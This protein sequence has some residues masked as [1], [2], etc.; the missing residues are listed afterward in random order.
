MKHAMRMILMG[1]V[2]ALG[3]AV[4]P[5][6]SVPYNVNLLANPG[7]ESSS[8]PWVGWTQIANG[9]DGLVAAAWGN[10]HSGSNLF[11]TSSGWMQRCQTNN[12]LSLGFTAA[13]LDSAPAI[14]VGEWFQTSP[15]YGGQFYLKVELRDASLNV[16]AGWTNGTVASPVVWGVNSNWTL[17]AHTFTNYGAGVR[18]VRFEDGGKD[19]LNWAGNYGIMLDDAYV[20]VGATCALMPSSN[21]PAAGGNTLI[22]TN[23]YPGSFGSGSDITNVVFSN[24]NQTVSATGANIL[25]QGS[26]WV[27]VVVPAHS[28]GSVSLVIQ[29]SGA[30]GNTTLSS[31]Q[32]TF[33][34][35]GSIGGMQWMDYRITF[36]DTGPLYPTNTAQDGA[37][38]WTQ[39][40]RTNTSSVELIS[41]GAV[42]NAVYLKG[43][44]DFG[45]LYTGAWQSNYTWIAIEAANTFMYQPGPYTNC[46]VITNLQGSSYQVD[47]VDAYPGSVY[48]CYIKVFPG[49]FTNGASTAGGSY[50][51]NASVWQNPGGGGNNVDC[52]QAQNNHDRYITWTNVVP[53]NGVISLVQ[54]CISGQYN[55]LNCMRIRGLEPVTGGAGAG[56]TPS[57]GSYT[58]G[59]PVTISGSNLCNGILGDVTNVTLCGITGVVASVAGSTQIVVTA[60]AAPN[61]SVLGD[62]RVYSISYGLSVKTNGFTYTGAG[63]MAVRGTNGAVIASGEAASTT[64]GT[65]FGFLT[66]GLVR[67]NTFSITNSGS[68]ALNISGVT[69]NGAGAS[70]FSVSNMPSSVAAGSA[71]N[72]TVRFALTNATT[73]AAAVYIVN[74]STTTPYIINLAGTGGKLSQT[75]SGFAPQN[76]TVF[77]NVSMIARLS[78]TASSGLAVTFATNGGPG[79]IAGGTNLSFSSTGVVYVVASQTGNV[80]YAAAP[81]VTNTYYCLGAPYWTSTPVTNA[82]DGELYTYT[83]TAAGPSGAPIS[84]SGASL[85]P[86]LTMTSAGFVSGDGIISTMAGNGSYGSTG[87]GGPATNAS[88][89]NIYRVG[90]DAAGNVY[91]PD[92]FNNRVRK[93]TAAGII[94]TIAGT[95]VAGWSGDGGAATNAKLNMPE[96]ACVDALGVVYIT[97]YNNNLIRRVGTNGIITTVAGTG[98]YGYSGDGGPATNAKLGCPCETAV[99]AAGNLFVVDYGNSR[100][101]RIGTNG[102]IQTIAGTGAASYNGDG[103]AATNAT[104]N[105]PQS[106]VVDTAGNVLVGDSGNNRIRRIGTNGIIRTIAGTGTSGY[107]GDEIAATNAQLNNPN[108]MTFDADGN[109]FMA[110]YGNNR[111]RRIGTNGIIS[112][113]AGSGIN[114]FSGDGGSATN[115]KMSA[116]GVAVDSA[117]RLLIADLYHNRIRRVALSVSAW[118]LS[119]TPGP[120]YVGATNVTLWATSSSGSTPQIFTLTIAGRARPL[121]LS[122]ALVVS[123]GVAASPVSGTDFGTVG[124]NT[125]ESLTLSITNSGTA[126]MTVSGISTSGANAAFFSIANL[127]ASLAVGAS[128]NFDISYRPMGEGPHAASF[129][130]NNNGTNTPYIINVAGSG[131]RSGQI[132]LNRGSMSYSATYRGINPPVQTFV[133]TNKGPGAFSYSNTDS[134]A[135]FT[136]APVTGYLA[137]G[138]AR[139]HTG[140]VSIA[141]SNAGTYSATN[142]ITSE[143]ATN[144]PVNMLIQLTIN[145]AT[146][147]I[148]FAAIADQKITNTVGLR[149]TASSSNAV[150]FY[151]MLGSPGVISGTNLT[152]TG[153]GT[154]WVVASQA[155]DVNYTAAPSVTNSINVTRVA[156]TVTLTNLNHTYDGNV[157]TASVTT[158]PT[159]LNVVVNYSSGSTAPSNAGSYAVTALINE[160]FYTGTATGTLVIARANQTINF[161]AIPNQSM[162]NAVGL[163]ATATSS[164]A[165]TFTV[166]SGMGIINGTNL[167]FAGAGQVKITAD[168]AGDNNWNAAPTVTN[169][170]SVSTI[171]VW[172]SANVTNATDGA[173]YTYTLTATD[174]GGMA[175]TFNASNL[176]PWLTLSQSGGSSIISTI[177]GKGTSAYSGDNGPA[178]NAGLAQVYDVAADAAGNIY[179]ADYN[180]CRIRKISTNGII[181]TVAGNGVAG[182]SGDGGQATNA[183]VYCPANVSVNTQGVIYITD[184]ASR[185]RRVGTNGIITLFAGT[186]ISSFSGDGGAATNARMNYPC[187]TAVDAVGKLYIAD[188]YNNRVR[189]VGTDGII[190]TIAG[191]GTSGF[192]GDGGPATS[193][194]FNAP[195]DVKVD[196]VGNV[197]VLDFGNNRVRKINTTSGVISTIAGTGTAGYNGDGISATNAKL[198]GARALALDTAGNVYVADYGNYR[199]RRIGTNGLISTIAGS[200]AN[201]FSGDGG[202]ATNASM[203]RP[204]GVVVDSSGNVVISD[205]SNYRIRRVSASGAMT[206]TLSGTPGPGDV[207]V[208]N[209]TLYANNGTLSTS[210]SF[211]ITV[212]GTARPLLLNR[213]SGATIANGAYSSPTLGTDFGTVGTN[214]VLLLSLSI[215]NFG[216]APLTISGVSTSGYNFSSFTFSNLP[217][218]V[219]AGTASN[220]ALVYAPGAIGTAWATL[221][222]TNNGTNSPYVIKVAGYATR[223]GA[224]G[225]SRASFNY[226]STYGG[227]NPVAQTYVITN[228]VVGGAGFSY[229]NASGAAWFSVNAVTGYLASA[230]L[231]PTFTGVGVLAADSASQ[232]HTGMVNCV[233][234]NAGSYTTTNTLSSPTASNS[235]VNMLVNLTIAQ[236]NQ[237]ITFPSVSD[238]WMTNTVGLNATAASGLPVSFNVAS[239]PGSISGTNLTFS[240]DGTVWVVA[241]QT[242]NLNY[243]AALAVTNPVNVSKSVATV[244]LSNL[245]Y[246]YDCNVHTATVATIPAALNVVVSYGGGTTPSNAGSYSVSAQVSATNYTGTATGTLVIARASQVITN[247]LPAS[248]SQDITNTFGLSA[249]ASSGLTVTNFVVVSGMATVTGGA[250][251]TF[252][253]AGS[254]LV[255]ATQAGDDNYNAA[256]NVTNTYTVASTPC[257]SSTPVTNATEGLIY[258]YTLTGID[259]GGL[260]VTFRT[261]SVPPWL[262]LTNTPVNSIISTFAGN[263]IYGTP[264]NGGQAT[265]SSIKFP[266][267][268]TYDRNGDV[269]MADL[270]N[271][272]IYK[273]T[274]SGVISKFAGTGVAGYSG[275]GGAATSAG[276]NGP[277]GVKA[278]AAGNIYISEYYGNRIRKVNTNGIISTIAGTGTSG[279]SGDGGAATSAKLNQPIAITVDVAGN[280]FVAEWPGYRI[281]MINPSGIISTFAG[282]G[283]QGFSGDGGAATNAKISNPGG[284]DTDSSGNLYLADT[285][286]NV[287]RRIG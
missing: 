187:G 139:I 60:G 20:N 145:Q 8:N 80:S 65:D 86:W 2:T 21:G 40:M 37:V 183:A 171:P 268:Q 180:A 91:V 123:N 188:Y 260:A 102:I 253:A 108:G 81:P 84:F 110:D 259:P 50:G 257:W 157:H 282:T 272:I 189:R 256:P 176:P 185:I 124:S 208:T 235:P 118:T 223:P 71:S 17:I 66:P 240:G 203:T 43:N 219:A 63:I 144:S 95:G 64:N 169:S 175:V 193:A 155:G 255:A 113:C 271:S 135:W 167:T 111:V 59:Y 99:D 39:N 23:F 242:G 138:T 36:K 126:A 174:P 24:T 34:P 41:T 286:N 281:R 51:L 233:G 156:A 199:I 88:F 85:P 258:T 97:D 182:N 172:T 206:W 42:L 241:S 10:Q 25:G 3:L 117:G 87:D 213:N 27:R 15:S 159:N 58:G 128:S 198:N 244:T 52:Q 210:N 46:T 218:V 22:I 194:T 232:T 130:I 142:T 164:N 190:Q 230:S 239:G 79:L 112:T 170:L 136:L 54:W 162:S 44:G 32:Y 269:Y 106:V 18:Y 265:N 125:I 184:A 273:I 166:A 82:T 7:G 197:Y 73:F 224:I 191:T 48:N 127:P 77:T 131:I 38:R 217:A 246:T 31:P 168:Q 225:L 209:V 6:F 236:A 57:S 178:T 89:S 1:L 90:A 284:L 109:L 100:I 221:S 62:V 222:L 237:T 234:M 179:M 92:S 283:T 214:E 29:S 153:E 204:I 104:L 56:V 69:T 267:G 67:T 200:G 76:G 262:T 11:A 238:Q 143:L 137:A 163:Y 227:A 243:A 277:S 249:Q 74:D 12:L 134:A 287:L 252:T 202:A 19:T 120:G 49:A 212:A 26:N 72:F 33:N 96:S 250:N 107:N 270:D 105:F 195:L 30:S 119:G 132:G 186:G 274:T 53:S 160:T 98:S 149:A 285:G 133:I 122:G 231:P 247:F 264:V 70:S 151:V 158:I 181:T 94:T 276:I 75:I 140:T 47:M 9:G 55:F 275:D 207:G 4:S 261:N 201:G 16:I 215:T 248:S 5:G 173:R 101:R 278:D 263:G 45:N 121:I 177:A 115:A 229:S 146:Q 148:T 14:T 83:L 68:V 152:F 78:A 61:V 228:K 245:S 216:T 205:Q 251:L 211:N 279:F 103:I 147:A 116:F 266:F 114:G 141:G 196:A 254:V 129:S 161:P 13:A 35:A 150:S 165:V 280:V 192:S 220:F 28:N 226:S 154:V 93:I